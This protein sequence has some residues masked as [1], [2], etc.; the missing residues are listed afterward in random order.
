MA[1]KASTAASSAASFPLALVDGSGAAARARIDED[2]HGH[3][4]L[5]DVLLDV[6][7]AGPR[8]DVPVDA[9]HFVARLVLPHLIKIHPAP[10]EYGVVLPCHEVLHQP[11]GPEFD[12]PD[13]LKP[14]AWNHGTSTVS[15]M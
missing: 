6:S 12:L 15:R 10:L 3:L 11:H 7:D 8:S 5:L 13:F 4:T 2:H 14:L 1:L 9:P